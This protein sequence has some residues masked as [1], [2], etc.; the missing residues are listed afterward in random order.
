MTDAAEYTFGRLSPG[1]AESCAELEKVLFTDDG[2]WSA[3]AFR[4]ELANAANFYAG[5]VDSTDRVRGYGGIARLGPADA[6]EYEIHTVGIDP[7]LQG[8]GMGRKLAEALLAVADEA[9]G[10]IFL[11]VRVDNEPAI[12]L[13]ESL[14]FEKVGLRKNYY[15][16]SGADAWTMKRS[17]HRP[18]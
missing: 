2:P 14:N 16:P 13:Y 12:S 15:R 9:P 1:A 17:A 8:H 10:D 11:E 3:D 6:P 4:S 5:F 7:T 18:S